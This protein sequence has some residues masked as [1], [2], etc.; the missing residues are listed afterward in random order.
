ME[1]CGINRLPENK[2]FWG[3][4]IRED[5]GH[6]FYPNFK[7]GGLI[8]LIKQMWHYHKLNKFFIKQ[9]KVFVIK[10]VVIAKNKHEIKKKIVRLNDSF[11]LPGVNAQCSL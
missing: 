5:E 11:K 7:G 9:N 6:R 8:N 4:I 3:V 10:G 2:V 1:G